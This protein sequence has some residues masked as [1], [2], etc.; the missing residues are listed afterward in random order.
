MSR[1][2]H[3]IAWVGCL[4]APIVLGVGSSARASGIASGLTKIEIP[5]DAK[6]N[7][8]NDPIT[9]FSILVKGLALTDIK[10]VTG[11]TIPYERVVQ[12]AGGVRITWGKPT[13]PPIMN[14]SKLTIAV[15]L[16]EAVGNK[17]IQIAQPRWYSQSE[18]V[19]KQ[20]PLKGFAGKGDPLYQAF[21]DL[22]SSLDNSDFI[23]HGL[24]FMT[25]VD[26]ISDELLDPNDATGFGTPLADFSLLAGASSSDWD[27]GTVDFGKFV[28]ARGELLDPISGESFGTFIDGY[29]FPI[30][31]PGSALL[32]LTAST[33]VLLLRCALRC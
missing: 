21:N 32:I 6:T 22:E 7:P 15:V 13:T 11:D 28:Y 8:D 25:N 18:L 3:A 27:V 4:L 23:V 30:P 29:G 12:E 16:T 2:R 17:T 14:G 33:G 31:E 24:Q 26:E 5:L 19:G 1:S 10:K 9:Q 20:V